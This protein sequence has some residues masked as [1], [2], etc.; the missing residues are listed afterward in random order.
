MVPQP[1]T[2]VA[3]GRLI[4]LFAVAASLCFVVASCSHDSPPKVSAISKATS[5]TFDAGSAHFE[6]KIDTTLDRSTSEITATGAIDF[7]ERK[8]KLDMRFP[9]QS[10]SVR[11]RMVFSNPVFYLQSPIFAQALPDKKPWV[12]MDL[13]AVDESK[14]PQF[15][16]LAQLSRNDPSD[17]I[18]AL[19]GAVA[20]HEVGVER[21]NGV[22]ATH[23]KATIDYSKAE[24]NAPADL[25]ETMRAVA[26]T[27]Q[28]TTGK[29]TVPVDVW[30]DRQ[31]KVVRQAL[32]VVSTVGAT[33]QKT[34]LR[35]DLSNYGV[36]VTVKLPPKKES[37]DLLELMR[38][39]G[40]AK[41]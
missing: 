22:K 40:G 12:R 38:G 3:G 27:L 30:V 1:G 37:V 5:A 32:T 24:R 17:F 9:T 25:Q 41:P 6:M 21:I 39:K 13:S 11:M 36:P 26:M 28:Q 16:Q 2:I 35:I 10:G 14:D 29:D 31:G 15:A 33:E 7:E 34:S 18:V 8:G 23:Y 19:R 4:R 20:E